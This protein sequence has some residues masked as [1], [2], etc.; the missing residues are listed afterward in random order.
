MT[1]SIGQVAELTHLSAHTLRFYE[2]EGLV[3][4][5]RTD[6]GLRDYNEEDVQAVLFINCMKK[7]GMS[8]ADIGKF[9]ELSYSS[10]PD[11]TLSMRIA[12]LA[13]Q[14]ARVAQQITHLEECRSYIEQKIKWYQDPSSMEK[15]TAPIQD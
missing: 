10:N 8:I 14:E 4:P 5:E 15:P 11:E 2:K 3:R 12:M 7:T 13:E 6:T 9:M 1:Y